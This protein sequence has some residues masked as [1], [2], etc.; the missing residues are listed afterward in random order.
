[1]RLAFFNRTTKRN[2]YKALTVA[3]AALV[4]KRHM[5][6]TKKAAHGGK[7]VAGPGKKLGRP[8]TG[9]TVVS[10]SITMSPDMWALLDRE[11]GEE[12]RSRYLVRIIKGAKGA[13]GR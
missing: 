1:M 4:L 11:R 12:T 2:G 7:R 9:R 8:P 5:E 10:S 13:K 3:S 6:Q